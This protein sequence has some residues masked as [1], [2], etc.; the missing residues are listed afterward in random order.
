MDPVIYRFAGFELDSAERQLRRDGAEVA[1]NARY[2]DALILLVRE[3]GQL[4]T[5]DRFMDA[6]WRGIPVT[7]EALT[8]CIRTLRRTLG[9]E[10]GDPRFIATVPKFGYRF[11]G[12]VEGEDAPSPLPPT[13]AVLDAALVQSLI[14]RMGATGT[15]GAVAAGV[16]GGLAYG[17]LGATLAV[18]VQSGVLSIVLVLACITIAVAAIGGGAVAFGIAAGVHRGGTPLAILGG[19]LAGL[20]VGAVAKLLGIDAFA[21]LLGRAPAGITGA[22]EG[23]ALGGAVGLAY[24]IAARRRGSDAR[25]AGLTGAGCGALA[26]LV[27]ALLGGRLLAGS[28]D[29]LTQTMD[30]A[31]LDLGRIGALLGESG[32]GLRSR[33]LT[34]VLE[35][36]LFGGLTVAGLWRGSTR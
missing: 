33:V 6:V 10:A 30:G 11:V 32:F 36:A 18:P 1:L 8:Q 7:D 31:R 26:G 24:W 34:G 12:T 20:V 17:V 14:W 21:L 16:I 4:V 9:D 3:R 5:K 29:V 2:L 19:A 15:A 35:G 13:P 23:L 27:I 22:P 25:F 28:I